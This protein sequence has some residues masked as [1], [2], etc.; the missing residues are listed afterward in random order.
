MII[1]FEIFYDY[2]GK[3]IYF[4]IKI[5]SLVIC[6]TS[7]LFTIP[8]FQNKHDQMNYGQYTIP[9]VSIITVM[10]ISYLSLSISSFIVFIIFVYI[11]KLQ[12]FSRIK[13]L[14]AIIMLIFNVSA[15][16]TQTLNLD[17]SSFKLYKQKTAGQLHSNFL[18]LALVT[19]L[20]YIVLVVIHNV[21]SINFDEKYVS[22]ILNEEQ[23]KESRPGYNL[24]EY[25]NGIHDV[26][27]E[28]INKDNKNLLNNQSFR[29]ICY[30]LC[31][32]YWILPD[33]CQ[34]VRFLAKQSDA[35]SGSYKTSIDLLISSFSVY[36]VAIIWV[37][38]K[39]MFKLS[40]FSNIIAQILF[41]TEQDIA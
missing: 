14:V 20:C 22:L 16:L 24:D 28:N 37:A 39:H 38:M 13:L 11:D 27:V 10:K 12:Y 32:W 2:G 40:S 31:L 34:Y 36:I 23:D 15:V 3:Y 1:A 33:L 29:L 17:L 21:C 26:D 8:I 4:N 7:I 25:D 6:I 18:F 5:L 30:C 41:R 9:D 35:I 19:Y